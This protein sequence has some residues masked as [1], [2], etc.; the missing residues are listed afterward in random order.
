MDRPPRRRSESVIQRSMLFRAWLFLGLICA[1]LE[2]AGFFYVLLKGGW[3]PGDPTGEGTPLHHTY[4][5]ATTMTF[6]GMVAGQMAPPSPPAPSAPRCARWASS[7]TACCC[8]GSHSSWSS[9]PS[10]STR[11]RS[12]PC[13]VPRPLPRTCSSSRSPSRSSCGAP[14]SCAAGSCGGARCHPGAQLTKWASEDADRLRWPPWMPPLAGVQDPRRPGFPGGVATPCVGSA[15]RQKR[16]TSVPAMPTPPV[17]G[18]RASCVFRLK[19]GGI[20]D[21]TCEPTRCGFTEERGPAKPDGAHPG[22]A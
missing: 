21:A 12:S 10:S 13:W 17:R 16:A 11:P 4:Q 9:R 14:M 18:G 1:V 5:Q 2:M 20:A 22:S 6:F 7:A 19:T 3:S 15:R 8:G